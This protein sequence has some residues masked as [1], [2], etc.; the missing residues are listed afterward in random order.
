[1]NKFDLSLDTN[2]NIVIWGLGFYGMNCL[3]FLIDSAN[4][5]PSLIVDLIKH[6]YISEYRGIPVIS[7][8]MFIENSKSNKYVVLIT[9]RNGSK[10][11]LQILC[12]LGVRYYFFDQIYLHS[13]HEVGKEIIELLD[14]DKSKLIFS[15]LIGNRMLLCDKVS[16][17]IIDDKQ[18]FCIP[19]FGRQK[20]QCFID[21]GAYVGDTFETWLAINEGNFAAYLGFDPVPSHRQ[22][23]EARY[24]RLSEEYDLSRGTVKYVNKFLGRAKGAV[25][26]PE[27]SGS[28]TSRLNVIPVS[29]HTKSPVS[30]QISCTT[31]DEE[32]TMMLSEIPNVQSILLKMDIEGGEFEALNGAK[33]FLNKY[34]PLLAISVYHRIDD[35]YRIPLFIKNNVNDYRFFIRHHSRLADETV[36][37]CQPKH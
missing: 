30:Q 26:F 10:F 20:N 17:E 14:D 37:Y 12:S 7:P 11:D 36:L 16:Q 8:D 6:K 5:Q 34:R 1:M 22:S 9:I 33:N 35:Y 28:N 19:D 21:C 23:F 29:D 25:N 18:Y 4:I 3:D 13:N 24:K 2:E 27:H 15:S 32:A 31:I